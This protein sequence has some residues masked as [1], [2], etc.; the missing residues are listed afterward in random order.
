MFRAGP[1]SRF[2]RCWRMRN[3]VWNKN[4][5][6]LNCIS[7]NQLYHY[8]E[9]YFFSDE[10]VLNSRHD[11]LEEKENLEIHIPP[12]VSKSEAIVGK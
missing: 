3:N 6:V 9:W 5:F 10:K 2:H 4:I 8:F 12:N 7:L 1:S 11:P